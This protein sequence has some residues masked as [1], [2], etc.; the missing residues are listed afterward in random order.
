M[1]GP[2]AQQVTHWNEVS[3]PKWVANAEL[4]DAQI[5]PIGAKAIE[6]AA[7]VQGERVL[8]VGCGCG[9]TSVE[10]GRR[11]G[12]GGG[13]LG[14]DLSQPMLEDARR[15]AASAGLGHVRFEQADAQVHDF[16][17]GH[18]DLA[19]SRFGVMFFED[20]ATAF[21]NIRRALRPGAR[22]C[23]VSWQEIGRNPWMV[24]PAM[25]AAKHVELA[26]PAGE[27]APGPFAF[28]DAK[29]VTGLLEQAGWNDVVHAS[30]EQEMV[31]GEGRA[32]DEIVEFVLQM[33]PAGTA[34][35]DAPGDVLD[36]VRETA[37]ADLAS[38]YANGALR[39]PSAAWLVTA[40][41]PG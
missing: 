29:R 26:A 35:R 34:L 1:S 41:A 6:R 36:A 16:V 21:S 30:L 13:V 32:L 39:M 15:R 22:L 25:S 5:A 7:I 31:I 18:F 9:Q 28:A 4:I 27:G 3:G 10:L 2:N 40:T 14:V 33:G 12:P 24:A 8:D 38:F 19:F 20:P 11:V 23:F 17:P 37:T